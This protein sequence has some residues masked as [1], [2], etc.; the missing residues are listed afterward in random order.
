[1]ERSIP[2][3][4]RDVRFK[5]IRCRKIRSSTSVTERREDQRKAVGLGASAKLQFQ[6]EA[7]KLNLV[8]SSPQAAEAVVRI[9]GKVVD[10]QTSGADVKDGKVRIQEPRLYEL[11]DLK[12]KRG[13]H[14][15]EIE[16][17]SPNVEGF[18][19]TFG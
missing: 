7:R 14:L 17:L 5:L 12:E 4:L 10:A 11:I 13:A 18:A 2:N 16:F 1:M 3:S 9:D 6:F 19:F 8:L 15:F